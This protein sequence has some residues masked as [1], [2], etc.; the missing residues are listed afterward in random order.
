MKLRTE[1]GKRF[2]TEDLP[3]EYEPMFC[4]MCGERIGWYDNGLTDQPLALCDD[5]A[6]DKANGEE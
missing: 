4:G 2:D 5:C 6:A 3:S 1:S